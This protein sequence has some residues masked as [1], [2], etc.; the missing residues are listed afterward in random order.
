MTAINVSLLAVL[1]FAGVRLLQLRP[2]GVTL[3]NVL[4]VAEVLYFFCIPWSPNFPRSVSM[5]IAGATGVGN[6]GI[7]PQLLT[8]YPIIALIAL[9]LARRK[10]V[11]A[12]RAE[13]RPL[14]L[15]KVLII[16]AVLFASM[17]VLAVYYG[18]RVLRELSQVP[19]ELKTPRVLVGEGV[20][21]KRSF[22]AGD[23][24][25]QISQ[26]LPGWPADREGAVLVIVGNKGAQFF[27]AGGK[28]KKHVFFSEDVYC[29]V[30]SVR[31]DASGDYGFLTR[32][33]SWFGK[34]ILFDKQGQRLWS[35][36]GGFR[37]VN[38]S[39]AG[40]VDGDGKAEFI[41]GFNGGGGI[42]LLSH[43][44]K[45]RWQ[46]EDRNV[47]HVEILDTN[48]DGRGEIVHS[49]A[50]GELKVRDARGQEIARFLSGSYV[51]FF[52]L[53]R[54]GGELQATHILIPGVRG[55]R[56]ATFF[57]LDS[58][59]NRV[60]QFDAPLGYLLK[61][62]EG[63]PV[64]FAGEATHYAILQSYSPWDRS[65]LFVYNHKGRLDYQEI[66]GENCQGLAPFSE[67]SGEVLLVGCTEK[68]W[69]YSLVAKSKSPPPR[70]KGGGQ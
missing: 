64:R 47:W 3:C 26:I 40:D 14:M 62:G 19:T 52:A 60:Q 57:I 24:L 46:A 58:R 29:P 45:K 38:D 69:T 39:A 9:S 53:T 8:A 16:V 7:A 18:H 55:T 30:Q 41:V 13:N 20:F 49:N 22:Y 11:P 61:V 35:Y 31:L 37:G 6:M 51:S 25:G 2:R 15:R 48:G 34:V 23:G 67:K 54:W 42:H 32:D 28:L 36:S 5:S 65:M 27:D 4:F 1:V 10:L 50:R 12:T 21:E 17:I 70:R 56:Q 66:I 44:G 63:T 43:Q 68:I 33:E 59:G